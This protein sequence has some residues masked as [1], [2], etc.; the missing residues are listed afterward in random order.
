MPLKQLYFHTHREFQ[1]KELRSHSLTCM[2]GHVHMMYEISGLH[3]KCL[4]KHF[5]FV[6]Q[7]KILKATTI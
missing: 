6:I 7:I 4:L 1:D 3:L 5:I 2:E